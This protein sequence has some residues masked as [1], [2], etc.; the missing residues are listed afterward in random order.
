VVQIWPGQTVTCL[1]TNRPSHI[2]TTLYYISLSV[3]SV[4]SACKAHAPYHT[5]ICGLSR[6][7]ILSCY[8]TKGTIFRKKV[9]KHE[10]F[11]FLHIFFNISHFTK[12]SAR[13]YHKWEYVF[14][15][16]AR[17]SC[18]I[19]IKLRDR[20]LKDTQM[21]NLMTLGPVEAQLFHADGQ[22]DGHDDAN[23]SHLAILRTRLKTRLC[24]QPGS[25][26]AALVYR[27]RCQHKS[28]DTS[29]CQ[30]LP[31]AHTRCHK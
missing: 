15:Y 27:S 22:T 20:V 31:A 18:Q 5:V 23:E 2:W 1:H 16:R 21:S 26:S 17:Y 6:S 10:S 25:V 12:N 28:S 19:L 4:V 30:Q 24:K 8:L 13:Y 7:T 3:R 9:I 14:M 29:I 11:D